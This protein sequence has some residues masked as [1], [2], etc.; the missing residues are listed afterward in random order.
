MRMTDMHGHR[1]LTQ[2]GEI[3]TGIDHR[4][5]DTSLAQTGQGPVHGITL[6]NTAEIEMKWP[7]QAYP[8]PRQQFDIPPIARAVTDKTVAWQIAECAQA[9]RHGRIEQTIG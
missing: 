2:H 1:G 6:G 3:A 8:L 7:M 9:R 5:V 4:L